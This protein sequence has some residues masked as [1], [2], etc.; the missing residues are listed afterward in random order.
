MS[1]L[2]T[3][4]DLPVPQDDGAADHLVGLRIPDITLRSTDGH[5]VVLSSS[6]SSGLH[7]IFCYPMTG[8]KDGTLPSDEWDAIPGAR[9]CTP[10]LCNI[11]D[12]LNELETKLGGKDRIWALST[13]SPEYQLDMHNRNHLSF[14]V[15]SDV[16]LGLVKGL[17]LP[18]FN[19]MASESS[20]E[21]SVSMTLVKR[22]T[23]LCKDGVVIK[24]FYPIFPSDRAAKDVIE[25]L[26]SS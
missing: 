17:N 6:M 18:S 25:Y 3:P 11:R 20:N 22:I 8:R 12:L 7:A 4:K 13:Q 16:D 19:V 9:G 21:P 23:L 5:D 14:P 1:F 24:A 10:E 15:L 2:S 26:A